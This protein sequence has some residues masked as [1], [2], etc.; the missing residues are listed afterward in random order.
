MGDGQST[1]PR[2][3]FSTFLR[4]AVA[5]ILTLLA[6]ESLLRLQQ[7]LGPVCDLQMDHLKMPSRRLGLHHGPQARMTRKLAPKKLYG[8]HCG[9]SYTAYYDPNGIRKNRLRPPYKGGSGTATILFMGDSFMQGYDD[10][11]TIPHHV[12]HYF[13]DNASHPMPIRL[14]NAGYSSYSPAVFIPQAKQLLPKVN[15]DFVVVD[16]DETDM[17]DDWFRYKPLIVRGEDGGIAGIRGSPIYGEFIGGLIKVREQPSFIARLFSKFYHTRI[18][19]PRFN[20]KWLRHDVFRFSMD[21]DPDAKQKYQE[22]ITFFESNVSE[23][24]RQLVGSLPNKERILLLYHPHLR[25]LRPDATNHY[26]NNF[27]SETIQKVAERHAVPFYNAT[28]DLKHRFGHRP[29]QYYW[30]ENMHFNFKGLAVYG[31]LVARQLLPMLEA[32]KCAVAQGEVKAPGTDV[33]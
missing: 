6:A 28:Q 15:P 33:P 22:Q 29:E 20:R 24:V 26:W 27:V 25:H 7:V 8:Q 19:M 10:A 12:W 14:L 30:K 18:H 17:G 1:R 9:H 2:S 5:A 21:R 16:I 13:H 23:L 4:V 11:N 31:E 32:A 3:N